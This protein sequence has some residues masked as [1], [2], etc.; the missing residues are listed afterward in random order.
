MI[1]EKS[2]NN[3]NLEILKDVATE[4][5]LEFD[6]DLNIMVGSSKQSKFLFSNYVNDLVKHYEERQKELALKDESPN[7]DRF[8]MVKHE[9]QKQEDR[10]SEDI[11]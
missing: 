5:G 1:L 2:S 11:K 7:V 8:N 6:K 10:K 4:I 3:S 9:E